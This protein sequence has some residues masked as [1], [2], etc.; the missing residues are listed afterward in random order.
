MN[1]AAFFFVLFGSLLIGSPIFA[2][3]LMGFGCMP[4]VSLKGEE[5]KQL[6]DK[7]SPLFVSHHILS[8]WRLDEGRYRYRQRSFYIHTGRHSY[9]QCS[10]PAVEDWL[11]HLTCICPDASWQFFHPAYGLTR[12]RSGVF[13][14]DHYVL[15]LKN[16]YRDHLKTMSKEAQTVWLQRAYRDGLWH[17]D[18]FNPNSHTNFIWRKWRPSLPEFP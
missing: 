18:N 12:T 7:A 2:S 17:P 4:E 5:A 15:A 3:P 8:G 13:P 11:N 9:F 16:L 10:A 14:L 1:K 6:V